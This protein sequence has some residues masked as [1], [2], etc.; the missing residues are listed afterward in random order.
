MPCVVLLVKRPVITVE[1]IPNETVTYLLLLF[2]PILIMAN[3]EPS[4]A[5]GIA[6]D[7]PVLPDVPN[8]RGYPPFNLRL[9]PTYTNNQLRY[10]HISGAMLNVDEE[11]LARQMNKRRT[12]L[13]A[14]NWD[15]DTRENTLEA[16]I[17]AFTPLLPPPSTS[18][19]L[20]LDDDSEPDSDCP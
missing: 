4:T 13:K 1:A 5:T 16:S 6:G 19:T 14:I 11:E 15:G 2:I 3:P 12:A 7:A 9:L 8:P 10:H 17:P 20:S 18:R